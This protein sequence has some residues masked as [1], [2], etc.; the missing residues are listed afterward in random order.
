M[1][2]DPPPKPKPEES[3][4]EI[5]KLKARLA[6]LEAETT[7]REKSERVKRAVANAEAAKVGQ[8]AA[9]GCIVVLVLMLV[10]GVAFCTNQ[11]KAPEKS[12]CE[13]PFLAYG[14]AQ[15]FVSERLKAPA[16]ADYPSMA[17]GDATVTPLGQ[18]KFLVSSYVDS[19]NGFGA[20]VRTRF[21]ATLTAPETGGTWSL[22]ALQVGQ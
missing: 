1:A 6:E 20:N 9:I 14:M 7:D 19:E 12:A 10:G 4:E 3:A 21:T 17:S 13:D 16:T 11:K 5:A 2:S 15:Q 8:P 18:C 22:D